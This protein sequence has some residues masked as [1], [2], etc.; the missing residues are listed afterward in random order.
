M[1]L[2]LF[3]ARGDKRGLA[4]QSAAFA[5]H[6]SPDKILG[7]DLDNS[8]YPNDWKDF[9]GARVVTRHEL[10]KG[11]I[12]RWF[13]DVDA[14]WFAETG[15]SDD[16]F[17][18]AKESAHTFL[19]ANPE[20]Y[21]WDKP[22]HVLANPTIWH[23]EH[24]EGAIHFPFPVDTQKHKFT[25]RT[26]AKRFVHVVG[27]PAAHDRAGTFLV[28]HA[29]RFLR[30]P[31]EIVIRTRQPL[32]VK[33]YRPNPPTQ[34]TVIEG[35][36]EDSTELYDGDVLLLPRR[37]GGQCLPINEA[38]A[39]GLPVIA[40]DRKPENTWLPRQSVVRANRWGRF[41]TQGGQVN[42]YTT[43]A[44]LIA[45][46]VTELHNDPELVASLSLQARQY[47]ESISWERLKGEFAGLLR[48]PISISQSRR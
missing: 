2:G 33:R 38:M 44:N 37:Y 8:P 9:N 21:H 16:T 19:H 36:T 5:R 46:K 17:P 26:E 41:R 47:A 34:L 18:V 14:V 12:E 15:Y 32:N 31:V 6:M 42:V 4:I 1:R 11:F 23:L 35:D 25:H 30:A 22:T 45:E 27:H 43:H 40:L 3:G 13:R 48:D 29:L 24:M 20:F 28:L 7:I 39:S 10:T